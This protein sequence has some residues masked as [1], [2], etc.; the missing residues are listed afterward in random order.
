MRFT[1]RL[2]VAREQPH[3]HHKCGGQRQREGEDS[4]SR[5]A[6]RPQRTENHR[7]QQTADAGCRRQQRQTSGATAGRNDRADQCHQHA[8]RSRIVGAEEGQGGRHDQDTGRS[9]QQQAISD[10]Q[11]AMPAAQEHTSGPKS[12]RKLTGRDREALIDE[13]RADEHQ[14]EKLGTEMQTMLEDKVDEPVAHRRER[15]NAA[16]HYHTTK[17]RVLEQRQGSGRNDC[18][19]IRHRRARLK[20]RHEEREY[21]E[22][23]HSDEKAG[24]EDD[25]E[26]VAK[27]GQQSECDERSEH[28]AGGVEGPVDTKGGSQLRA[29]ATQRDQRRAVR[30]GYPS[31]LGQRQPRRQSTPSCRRQSAGR[32]CRLRTSRSP[33]RQRSCSFLPRSAIQPLASRSS[34]VTP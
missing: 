1:D 15:Q 19:R 11:Q 23:D 26:G 17:P 14:R 22:T 28:R 16:G 5:T 24:H 18:V 20:R 6:R 25:V 8:I 27:Q 29:F 31:Q 10:T 21:P 4:E 33:P 32:V 3:S 34:A 30:C 9:N 12:I 2:P 13:G 7:G